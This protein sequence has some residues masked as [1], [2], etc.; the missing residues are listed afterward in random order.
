MEL[1][2]KSLPVPDFDENLSREHREKDHDLFHKQRMADVA[3]FKEIKALESS[4]KR[5]HYASS[6]SSDSSSDSSS[7][8][9]SSQ[10]Q[11][12]Q[13]IKKSKKAKKKTKDAKKSKKKSKKKSNKKKSKKADK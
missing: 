12:S 3:F 5:R 9:G 13:E 4:G 11:S 8:H 6:T 2:K 1:S 10:S 7:D